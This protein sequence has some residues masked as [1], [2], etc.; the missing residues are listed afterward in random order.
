MTNPTNWDRYFLNMAHTAASNSKCLSVKVGAVIVRDRKLLV[1]TGYNG[2]PMGIES[3]ATR[4]IG[5]PPDRT[6]CPRNELG[7]SPGKG[8]WMCRSAHAELN[9]IVIAARLGTHTDGCML[10]LTGHSA[11]C[12]ECAKAII[13]SGIAEVVVDVPFGVAL[14]V[15]DAD[16]ITGLE[17]LREVP[18]V[19]RG[20]K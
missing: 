4:D 11:P 10:Y 1:S 14:T 5:T 19:V 15:Y 12:R 9:A 2:P 3:C 7:F 16:G 6:T 13:N 17:L 18:I 20:Y 8:L